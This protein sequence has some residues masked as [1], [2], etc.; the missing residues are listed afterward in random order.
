VDTL[1]AAEGGA[2]SYAP[3]DGFADELFEASGRPP[4]SAH[5]GLLLLRRQGIASRYVSG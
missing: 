2:P 5:L 1:P 3:R 4:R